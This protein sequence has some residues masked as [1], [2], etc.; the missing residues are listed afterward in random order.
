MKKLCAMI[1]AFFLVSGIAVVTV[2]VFAGAD[3]L[4]RHPVQARVRGRSS[5]VL[6]AAA[7][8]HPIRETSSRPR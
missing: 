7:V 6:E 8:R 4:G 3:Q 1:G 2:A 5:V